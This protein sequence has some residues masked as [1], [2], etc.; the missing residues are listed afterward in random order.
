ML[1]YNQQYSE[2]LKMPYKVVK[3]LLELIKPKTGSG[4]KDLINYIQDF[5]PN[6]WN[7]GIEPEWR[8]E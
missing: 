3:K 5:E 1:K 2:I 7:P 8:N 4:N 6:D